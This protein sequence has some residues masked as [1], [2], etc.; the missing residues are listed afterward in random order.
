MALSPRLPLTTYQRDVWVSALRNP[1]SAQFNALVDVTITGPVDVPLLRDCVARSVARHE[2]LNLRFG[3]D[4]GVPHQ[5]VEPGPPHAGGVEVVDLRAARDPAGE[6]AAWKAH[7]ARVPF[8]LTS[9][10]P[11][12]RLALVRESD[13][14]LHLH[15][16]IH[17]I[18]TDA[19]SETLL[20]QEILAD[21]D[22]VVRSGRH[23][24]PPGTAYTDFLPV[25]AEF[26]A[27]P[28][29]R[30]TVAAVAATVEGAAPALFPRRPSRQ[31]HDTRTAVHTF[32]LGQ[33]FVDAV[34]AKGVTPTAYLAAV[35]GVLLSRTHRSDDIV[36]GLP[37]LNR[38]D[39]TE[40][41]THGLFSSVLPLR[42]RPTADLTV[43]DLVTEVTARIGALRDAARV[44]LGDVVRS[45]PP[46]QRS[47]Q[48]FDV[49]FSSLRLPAQVPVAELAYEMLPET[50]VHDQ[51]ALSVLAYSV[52]GREGL[53]VHLHHALDVFDEDLPIRTFA[54]AYEHA[55][56]AGL[57]AFDRPVG[58][59]ALT[60]CP[61]DS[62]LLG[63][64]RPYARDATLPELFERQV[65][66]HPHRTA[67]IDA[68]G[69][70]T[71]YEQLARAADRIAAGLRER[72]VRCGDRVA[73]VME[74]G[75]DLMAALFGVLKAGAAYVPV[76]PG[77]P[78]ERI[79]FMVRDS[80]AAA[81]ITG[82]RLPEATAGLP[83]A[84]PVAELL[85]AREHP[86]GHSGAPLPERPTGPAS[87]RDGAG[88]RDLAY[89]I[90][91]SGSTGT[92]KGVM[93][94][95][96]SVINRLAWMQTRYPIGP[97]DV[98]LQKTPV[99]FDVS[100]WELFWWSIEGATLALLA[101]GAEKDPQQVLTAVSENAVTAVHFVPSMFGSF[102]DLLESDF[103]SPGLMG[104]VRHVFCSGE[105]LPPAQVERFNRHF[106]AADRPPLL[107]NLYGPTEATV[108]VCA[109]DCPD[110]PVRRVPIGRPIHN[111]RLAVV[112]ERLRPVPPGFPGELLIGGAGVARGYLDR[113]RLTAEKFLPDPEHPG[114]RLYRTGDLA[115]VLA[116]GTLEYL[117][118]LDGQV[119]V[120]GNRVEPGE[121]EDALRRVPGVRAAAVIDQEP[122]GRGKV[123][124]GYYV[125]AAPIPTATLRAALGDVLPEFMIPAF[126]ERVDVIPLTPNGKADRRA[127]PA[128][129]RPTASAARPMTPAERTLSQVW[130]EVLG[131]EAVGPD[132]D[133]YA[134]GGDSLLMLRIRA[135]AGRRGLHFSLDDLMKHRTVG[136]LAA[137]AGSR[138]V[139]SGTTV[140]DEPVRS[141]FAL[142]AGVD[143]ARLSDA[144]DAFPVSRLQLGLIYHSRRTERSAVYKDVFRYTLRMPWRE[145]V[146]RAA[147]ARLVERHPVLRSGFRLTGY[148]EPL[149][150]V[151]ATADALD[152]V[153]L[154]GLSEEA[155]EAAVSRHV[156]DRRHHEYSFEG[157]AP[158]HLLRAHVR[159]GGVVLVLS[160]H[161]ALLDGSSVANLVSELLHEYGRSLGLHSVPLPGQAPPSPA[162]HAY[163]ERRAV[164]SE[165][166]KAFWQTELKG[167]T[168]PSLNVFGPHEPRRDGGRQ[169]AS[170]RL[171]LSRALVEDLRR[172]A[173]ERSM[174]VKS[175]LLTAHCLTLSLLGGSTDVT[176]GLITHSRPEE[177]GAERMVGLFLNTLPLRMQTAATSW[178]GLVQEA[179][180]REQRIHPH[181]HY[182]LSLIQEDLGDD[183]FDTAFNYVRF[184]QLS[185][186]LE[187]PGIEMT[188][189]RTFEQTNFTLLVNAV[190]DPVDGS[191]WLRVDND[192]QN[193]TD[194][195]VRVYGAYWTRILDRLV[196]RPDEAP[197]LSFLTGRARPVTPGAPPATVVELFEAQAERTPGAVAVTIGEEHW[198]Y[199]DLAAGA[200]TVARNVRARGVRPGSVVGVA[201]DRTPRTV[202]I[203]I[204]VLRAGA[205]VMPLDTGYPRR[206]LDHM[207]EHAEP[208]LI[209]A[210]ERYDSLFDG[211]WPLVR[212]DE[213]TAGGPG[214]ARREDTDEPLPC[215]DPDDLAVVLYTSGSTGRPK[216]VAVPHR[217]LGTVVSWQNRAPSACTGVTLQY[218]ALSFDVSLQEI[219][220][221]LC[222]G[223]TLCLVPEEVRRDIPA[224]LRLIDREGVE[225]V[226]MPYV[227]LQQ[228]A[229][230]AVALDITP[231]RLRVI[232]CGGEQ[233]RVTDEIRQLC[234]RLPGAVLE[235]HYGPTETHVVTRHTLTGPAETYPDLPPVGTPV[236]DADVLVLDPALR[237]LPLGVT[238]EV[239]IGGPSV[240]LGYLGRED[241]TGERFVRIPGRAGRYY[242]TGDL[243]F[244]LPGGEIVCVG[245]ADTQVKVRGYRVETAEV[246][247]AVRELAADRHPGIRDVAVVAR[248]GP[249]AE[250]VLVAYLVGDPDSVASG[251]LRSALRRTLPDYM[252]PS[253]VQWLDALPSTPSGKR[254]DAALRALPL[255]AP[256]AQD[257]T[258]PRT[259][260]ERVL[261]EILADLLRVPEIGV[262]DNFFDLGGTSL[263]AMRLMVTVEE[264]FRVNV[265]LSDLI[266]APTVAALAD[267][268][269]HSS[270]APAPF[271]AVVPIKPSGSRAPLFLVHPMGGNV[272]C[273]LPFARHLPA[274]QPLY[275]L[276][277]AGADPGT[278]PL[279]S[280]EEMARSYVEAIR[281]VQ[282]TGPYAIAGYSFGGFVA[283]E[284]SRQL[285]AAGAEVSRTLLFDSVALNPATSGRHDDD[286]LLG[287]FFW[288][289]LW[290]VRGGTSPLMDL[291]PGATTT[292]EK[293]DHIADQAVRLGV[294]PSDSSGSLIRRLF[295]VYRANWYAAGAYRPGDVTLDLTLLRSAEP[296]PAFLESMHGP[297]GSLHYEP[298]NGWHRMTGGHVE[299]VP[300]AGDHLSM[301]E[302]PHVA[303]LAATVADLLAAP[304]TP[305][306]ATR[307]PQQA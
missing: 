25:E 254:D 117:G 12:R 51:D 35:L 142:V 114:E 60:D 235:N 75:R 174:P 236:E 297:A 30:H 279:G 302:E 132:D 284:M 126:F 79:E 259:E 193:V 95:H 27:S 148:T 262:H 98:L 108:D 90:Y 107:T 234:R 296:L 59:L 239:Y 17:H 33:D 118:R 278:V 53:N 192:G 276:Q 182:P 258:P 73:V 127:L 22:S 1:E 128:P 243:A 106:A 256:A 260:H 104:R 195:Q 131:V 271:D 288:E 138:P 305:G 14:L 230:A 144:V 307:P 172:L 210:A 78:A 153:D 139:P 69:T 16:A 46:E 304:G 277:S 160:F 47:R 300:V 157:D 242:R 125:A 238:G 23:T 185:K 233:L 32:Q 212:P 13:R 82:A 283:F 68:D 298:T 52:V 164:R 184:E 55:L 198:T 97:G 200:A 54:A 28:Q 88:P 287:W 186:T 150:V 218:A 226:F 199:A 289:L 244:C 203:M 18:C 196:H 6:V 61:A 64:D 77:Y 208:A 42:T 62:V 232:V 190:T 293:F 303:P 113:P 122:P 124:V 181:R 63:E 156:E 171:T 249:G 45:L 135:L 245:R 133:Y 257:A 179:F 151:R 246:E 111:T 19:W 202:A 136:A 211:R 146:F 247:L 266:A 8:D 116:D 176:T 253:H 227:A 34:R 89:V 201:A 205:A 80:A 143:R 173:R 67:L 206:R 175:L 215:A 9:G 57:A 99:S 145:E 56:R 216:A 66:L 273:F 140:G 87:P 194:D 267:R 37:L 213:L 39:T 11:P 121:V 137:H 103:R 102:L 261:A 263:T 189:V 15:I 93:V 70:R 20:Y 170:H 225:R 147:Y 4:G 294:L 197:D 204:G 141:P 119:K 241:L 224:L 275:G 83:R 270:A 269:T 177:T 221:T 248:K 44:G 134:L 161:H 21:Y 159:P 48:L 112:D 7:A 165:E 10:L 167:R 71:S 251:A 207:V 85:T 291:P 290:P 268:L 286:V 252:I 162:R 5:W 49:T 115:R 123:L 168:A 72:G 65:A 231:S 36:L 94:E 26:R 43:R 2:A 306:S 92:P 109:Y 130:A 105:A 166:S 58:D 163:E 152:V 280:V 96:H 188:D 86:A 292:D 272:L 38:A 222:G 180:R 158:C 31:P 91:T 191:L 129:G 178:F 149:Q 24:E 219:F 223:G 299:V 76:D 29:F 228:L 255:Q 209:I 100:V 101:P 3:D 264:R 50:P 84:V 187:L 154:R 220:S 74:R 214:T 240:A 155:A 237:P 265:P 41:R 183:L 120:R 285:R 282:P 40:L 229:A 110:G 281:R 217:T 274:E 169:P 301:M 81:V 295:R 250:T